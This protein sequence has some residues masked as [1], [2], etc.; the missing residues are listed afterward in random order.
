MVYQVTDVV[1]REDNLCSSGTSKDKF[2]KHVIFLNAGPM[3][4]AP[5]SALEQDN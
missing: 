3:P 5:L 1:K 4:N 2:C